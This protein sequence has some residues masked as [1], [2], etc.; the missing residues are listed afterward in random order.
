MKKLTLLLSAMLLACATNLWAE[1]YTIEFLTATSDGTAEITSKTTVSTVVALG[2]AYVTGF[3][4]NCSKAYYKGKSGVKLGSGS[5]AGTFEFNLADVCK[6]NVTKI[7]VKS[8][9]YDSG[10]RYFISLCERRNYCIEVRNHSGYGL[11]TH[12]HNRTRGILN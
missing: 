3:T 5:A 9:K 10:Y 7:T 4:A 6:S 11:C 2:T 1:T 12:F 8:A